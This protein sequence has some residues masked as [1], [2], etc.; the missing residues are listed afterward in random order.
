[1]LSAG[2]GHRQGAG[3][4]VRGEGAG[5]AWQAGSVRAGSDPECR[6]PGPPVGLVQFPHVCPR[7]KHEWP[8]SGVS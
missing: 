3:G 8:G 1:M 7:G 2:Q 4:W 5:R 6:H